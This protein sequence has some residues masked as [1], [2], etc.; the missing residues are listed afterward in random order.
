MCVDL[1]PLSY[2]H[3]QHPIPAKRSLTKSSNDIAEEDPEQVTPPSAVAAKKSMPSPDSC[4]NVP[5]GAGAI[6]FPNILCLL[7][8]ILAIDVPAFLHTFDV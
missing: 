2:P 1:D 3:H 4:L 6:I 7:F 8:Q 5:S